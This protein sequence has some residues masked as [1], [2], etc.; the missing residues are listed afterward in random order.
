MKKKNVIPVHDSH[1]GHRSAGEVKGN[2]IHLRE[3]IMANPYVHIYILYVFE[4]YTLN[5]TK[6]T[7][8]KILYFPSFFL[9]IFIFIMNRLV[10][11]NIV[12]VKLSFILQIL[13]LSLV[14]LD[15]F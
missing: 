9:D 13:F 5:Q 3:N 1:G 11:V 10:L 7:T 2:Y 4:V 6:T 14:T 15:I 8:Y 12:L